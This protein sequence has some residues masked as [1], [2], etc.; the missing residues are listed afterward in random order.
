MI[1]FNKIGSACR[2]AWSVFEALC[3]KVY[4][5]WFSV[6]SSFT[7]WLRP[8]STALSA[9]VAMLSLEGP[10]LL[11]ATW[12]IF[13]RYRKDPEKYGF[14]GQVNPEDKPAVR[15][16]IV[17]MHG[18][19]GSWG[20]MGDL[21]TRLLKEGYYVHAIDLA[22][23]Q[24]I[25][26]CLQRHVSDACTHS[27]KQ[28]V[29]IVAHSNGANVVVDNLNAIAEK[30]ERFISVAMP[31]EKSK[32]EQ[33]PQHIETRAILAE[34]DAVVDNKTNAI[35]SCIELDAAHIGIVNHPNL[36]DEIGRIRRRG[37]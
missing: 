19:V 32:L 30:V 28:K 10:T 27:G 35:S 31:I 37:H 3:F 7:G 20:Y 21:A 4:K 6:V 1:V 29:T 23:C 11:R 8:R 2:F 14:N 24:N 33:F 25:E 36:V 15:G 26:Q 12:D 34:F 17:L 5:V 13:V 18:A 16:A 22:Q 9:G